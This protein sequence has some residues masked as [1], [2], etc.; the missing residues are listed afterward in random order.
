MDRIRLR[1]RVYLEFSGYVSVYAAVQEYVID[2]TA[3]L[4]DMS[5][6]N[7][8]ERALRRAVKEDVIMTFGWWQYLLCAWRIA[9]LISFIIDQY[10]QETTMTVR[11]RAE[12]LTQNGGD[13]K[14]GPS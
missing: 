10:R 7:V 1:N 3:N 12:T 8:Q 6:G 4:L 9:R 5:R 2:T 14:S 11:A 13:P